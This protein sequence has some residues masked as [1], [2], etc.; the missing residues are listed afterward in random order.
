VR[1]KLREARRRDI[2]RELD[3]PDRFTFYPAMTFAHKNHIR[4][5]QA[6][7]EL[8]DRHGIALPLLCTG[9]IHKPH[10]LNVHGEIHRLGLGEQVRFLGPLP[11]ESLAAVFQSASFMVFPSLFE[12]L[13]QS[14]LEGLANGVPIVAAE[15]SS[16]PETVGKAALLFDG[17]DVASIKSALLHAVSDPGLLAEIAARAP[18][19]LQ[20]YA[21]RDAGTVLSACY[22]RA[23]GRS[24]TAEERDVLDNAIRAD[25][26]DGPAAP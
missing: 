17:L 1:E 7:A 22:K 4:L 2:A 5:I 18:Y 6:L 14:L 20:R 24:L 13:S 8:R 26:P 23:A 15:Q 3:L 21:W 25:G 19:E 9:R 11:E 12:G 16:I 10:F